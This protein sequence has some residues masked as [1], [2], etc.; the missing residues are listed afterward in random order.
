[1]NNKVP[2]YV[3]YSSIKDWKFCPF[4][5]KLTRV[6]KVASGTESIHTAF[7]KA[8]HSTIEEI[9]LQEKQD[10]F[11][12]EKRFLEN[13]KKEFSSL[14]QQIRE[15]ISEKDRNDFCEQGKMLA[16]KVLPACLEYFGEFEFVSA[17]E[18]LLEDIR[19]YE[20]DDFKFKGYIDLV[21]KTKSDQKYHIIDWKTCSWGWDAE[22]RN[23]SLVTYQLTFYKHYFSNKYKI[24]PERIETHFGLLKRTAKKDNVELFRV[25]SGEKKVNNA[26]K[27]LK[28]C[29]YNVDN[30]RF[31][32]NRLSCSKC[33][34]H[35]TQYC[36]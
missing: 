31:I 2:D 29:V 24:D 10:S 1:M 13:F 12:Y 19:E 5:Y 25:T 34:F 28:E 27:L 26:L 35:K 9:F 22:K 15:Q 3:S 11:D 33:Q 7:G 23:D 20:K 4:Y 16:T 14:P 17:E 8:V 21:L 18:E 30:E 6:D 36:P 32:K